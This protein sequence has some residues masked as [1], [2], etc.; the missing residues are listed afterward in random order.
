[1]IWVG[2]RNGTDEDYGGTTVQVL[3]VLIV[4]KSGF[5]GLQRSI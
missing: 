5:P 1:M 3:K 2:R 4:F